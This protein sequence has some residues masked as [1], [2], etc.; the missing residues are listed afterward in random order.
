M[1]R[2]GNFTLSGYDELEG[3]RLFVGRTVHA[4]INDFAIADAD[5]P[6]IIERDGKLY[7][8]TRLGDGFV[9]NREAIKVLK[10]GGFTDGCFVIELSNKT[11]RFKKTLE[12]VE[13]IR[14]AVEC[15]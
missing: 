1:L 7:K 15:S 9:K 8:G 2:I 11:D 13:W 14:K 5:Y 12:S 6:C 3:A 10:D 4:H